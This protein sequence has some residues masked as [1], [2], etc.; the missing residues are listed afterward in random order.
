MIVSNLRSPRS[1]TPVA[2]QYVIT[3]G[4]IETFQS[5]QTIIA[6]RNGYNYTISSDFNY[7]RTTSRYFTEWLRDCGL[8]SLEIDTLKKWLRKDST[9]DGDELIELLGRPISIKFVNSLGE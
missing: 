4:D 6:K 5:Y 3:D 1:G 2:N 9:K 8:N 7:S